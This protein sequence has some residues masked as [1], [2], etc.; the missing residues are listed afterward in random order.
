[1]RERDVDDGRENCRETGTLETLVF[2]SRVHMSGRQEWETAPA[3]MTADAAA[4]VQG[5]SSVPSWEHEIR[6]SLTHRLL[7][8]A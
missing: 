7:V 1:M 6:D 5:S 4:R 8:T 3:V 2:P